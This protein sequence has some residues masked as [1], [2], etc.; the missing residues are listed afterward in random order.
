M[1]RLTANTD[2][3][4]LF[5]TTLDDP[6]VSHVEVIV[7]ADGVDP[8]DDN[9]DTAIVLADGRAYNITLATPANLATLLARWADTGENHAGAYLDGANWVIV[10]RLS[11]PSIRAAVLAMLDDGVFERPQ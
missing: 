9:A 2:Q 8:L 3:P 6:R 10:P 4:W 7:G 1:P 11:E 5:R